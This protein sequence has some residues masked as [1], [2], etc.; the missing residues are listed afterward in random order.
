MQI[1][2][3]I[4]YSVNLLPRNEGDPVFVRLCGV[5]LK[6]T[7]L[8]GDRSQSAFAPGAS[9]RIHGLVIAPRR[10]RTRARTETRSCIQQRRVHYGILGAYPKDAH[11]QPD[12]G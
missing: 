11:K 5:G 9:E 12:C 8:F 10:S 1:V 7:A 2:A 3:M 4:T 6:K